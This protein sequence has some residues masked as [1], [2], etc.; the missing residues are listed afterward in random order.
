MR[1]N[2]SV[3]SSILPPEPRCCRHCRLPACTKDRNRPGIL[4]GYLRSSWE[5]CSNS[6]A[7]NK[8]VCLKMLAKPLNP[9]VNDHYPVFKWL[10]HWEDL[11]NSFRQTTSGHGQT[12]TR[13][14]HFAVQLHLSLQRGRKRHPQRNCQ[15][16]DGLF[17]QK[18]LPPW[19]KNSILKLHHCYRYPSAR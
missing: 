17:K 16:Q 19:L 2:S 1:P 10:F 13:V 12:G 18:N 15:P 14:H 9:M 7:T 4:W 6:T 3:S 5:T 11:P 8:W